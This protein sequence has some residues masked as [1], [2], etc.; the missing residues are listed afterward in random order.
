MSLR[1]L[2]VTTLALSLPFAAAADVTP[3]G[4]RVDKA[5]TK[6]LDW[7]RGEQREDGSI[8]GKATGLALLAFLEK[9]ESAD[10]TAPPVGYEGSTPEDQE[11]MRRAVKYILTTDEAFREFDGR[12]EMYR[13]GS[14]LLALTLYRRTGGPDDVGAT[15]TD[16]EG[17]EVPLTVQQG[18]VWAALHL[19]MQQG[20]APEEERQGWYNLGGWNYWMPESDGDLSTTQF[21][22]AGLSSVLGGRLFSEAELKRPILDLLNVT[23]DD[24]Q[25]EA[26]R[27][28]FERRLGK[29]DLDDAYFEALTVGDL[30]DAIE[31][32]L[33]YA[34]R[35]GHFLDATSNEDGGH[36]YRGAAPDS[37]GRGSSHAMTAT[38]VWTYR[39]AGV[40]T[41]DPRVQA[42]IRWLRDWYTYEDEAN[43]HGSYYYYIWAFAKSMEVA[44]LTPQ[45]KAPEGVLVG[46]ALGGKRDPAADGFPEEAAAEQHDRAPWYYDFAWRLTDIQ[47]EDGSWPRCAP[48]PAEPPPQPPEPAVQGRQTCG[49]DDVSTAA[50]SLLILQ[51]SLGGACVDS[52]ADGYCDDDDNCPD[53]PNSDQR[54]G[55][56]DGQGDACSPQGESDDGG[57]AAAAAPT[58]PAT[59]A[60]LLTLLLALRLRRRV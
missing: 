41:S 21:A 37:P 22:M 10:W 42:A 12:A 43:W 59:T 30:R 8:G 60:L 35:P 50:F 1:G 7:L 18:I 15:V 39:L 14:S 56:G 38:A 26:V 29:E 33:A 49:S 20:L 46:H 47:E 34:A 51:R 11:R 55:D 53:T 19:L 25:K 6:G 54:D 3:F 31:S 2:L 23:L 27:E 48:Q 17:K 28:H 32:A 4:E 5:I 58:A 13:T 45:E 57:C 40:P 36:H 24:R 16:A 44:R 52:D 9:R